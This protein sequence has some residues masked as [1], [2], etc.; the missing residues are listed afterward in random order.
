MPAAFER[1][2]SSMW[3]YLG[4]MKADINRNEAVCLAPY[5]KCWNRA[6]CERRPPVRAGQRRIGLSR[7][8]V[9]SGIASHLNERGSRPDIFRGN[10]AFGE[11][12]DHLLMLPRPNPPAGGANYVRIRMC[13]R[14]AVHQPDST[15]TFGRT[16]QH[17]HREAATV[18]RACDDEWAV[19]GKKQALSTFRERRIG[20]HM[21]RRRDQIAQPFELIPIHASVARHCGQKD[22]R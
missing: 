6:R 7:K 18:G 20:K 13:P 11:L 12:R 3:H 21:N 15:Y 19:N 5:E 4:N 17:F 14:L 16:R 8:H 22:E 10:G 2:E 1:L 9:R